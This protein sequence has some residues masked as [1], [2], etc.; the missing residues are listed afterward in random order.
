MTFPAN[1]WIKNKR[2]GVRGCPAP[3]VGNQYGRYRE[4]WHLLHDKDGARKKPARH[5]HSRDGGG[6]RKLRGSSDLVIVMEAIAQAA[7]I[8]SRLTF[9]ESRKSQA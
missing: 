2:A 6:D 1:I 8:G 5:R 4:A 3:C 7:P 9:L